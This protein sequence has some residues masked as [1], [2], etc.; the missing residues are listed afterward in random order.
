MLSHLDSLTLFK[1]SYHDF[2]THNDALSQASPA[3]AHPTAT[4]RRSGA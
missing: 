3:T 2:P 1:S 4:A